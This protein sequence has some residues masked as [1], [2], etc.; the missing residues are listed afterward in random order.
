[1]PRTALATGIERAG[2][3]SRQIGRE[4]ETTRRTLG[5]SQRELGERVGIS[6]A[7]VSRI[8][9]GR[10]DATLAGYASIGAALGLELSMRVYPAK[11][12]VLRDEKQLRHVEHLVAVAHPSW[13]PLVEARASTDPQDMRAIDLVLRSAVEVCCFEVERDLRD[14]QAQLRADLLKRDALAAREAR[15]VRFILAV[16]DT[17]RM[18][19]LV[20]DHAPFIRA[21]LP[22]PSRHIWASIRSGK[23]ID[24][25][26]LLW[27]P[28][29]PAR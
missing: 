9:A 26:D 29:M 28:P 21:T 7:M 27:L 4:Y 13:S 15:P 3:M 5:W 24:A 17:R 1:V 16:P 20:R 12:I 19:A 25:D 11:G 23:P 6:Q 14:W 18:R 8:E 22:A 10:P 2:W